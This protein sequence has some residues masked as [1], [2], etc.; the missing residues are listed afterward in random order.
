[1][2]TTCICLKLCWLLYSSNLKCCL[3]W[4]PQL[5]KHKDVMVDWFHDFFWNK[6][7]TVFRRKILSNQNWKYWLNL[8]W[9]WASWKTSEMLSFFLAQPNKSRQSIWIFP[10][11]FQPFTAKHL[12][13]PCSF[14]D[15]DL[16]THWHASNNSHHRRLIVKI[17]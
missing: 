14:L 15:T 9:K 1:M 13:F 10:V 2:F 16:C 5:Q 17:S 3:L 4:S 6:Q 7:F 11:I 12:N 8:D